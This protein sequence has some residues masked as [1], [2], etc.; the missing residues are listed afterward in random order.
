MH[1]LATVGRAR[2][3]MKVRNSIGAIKIL[4][5]SFWLCR[6][7]IAPAKSRQQHIFPHPLAAI[8]NGIAPTTRQHQTPK[9]SSAALWPIS[10]P[11]IFT[12]NTFY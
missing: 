10:K 4:R 8:V 7:G 3:L 9:H 6:N 5:F 11:P 1:Q 2:P 12:T